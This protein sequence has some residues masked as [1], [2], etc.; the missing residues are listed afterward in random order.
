MERRSFERQVYDY[1]RAIGLTTSQ[2]KTEV[3]RARAMCGELQYDTDDSALENEQR[4]DRGD[5]DRGSAV[6]HDAREVTTAEDS[7]RAVPAPGIRASFSETPKRKSTKHLSSHFSHALGTEVSAKKCKRAGS[8]VPRQDFQAHSPGLPIGV[9]MSSTAVPAKQE[10]E[11]QLKNKKTARR[12]S[13]AP[14]RSSL[15]HQVTDKSEACLG[16]E[17]QADTSRGLGDLEGRKSTFPQT[18]VI[19]RISSGQTSPDDGPQGRKE[20]RMGSQ[21]QKSSPRKTKKQTKRRASF[22]LS[23]DPIVIDSDISDRE[24]SLT[25]YDKFIKRQAAVRQRSKAQT[26]SDRDVDMFASSPRQPQVK[27][28]RRSDDSDDETG[29]ADSSKGDNVSAGDDHKTPSTAG[30]P[31]KAI[32]KGT[33]RASIDS[34]KHVT[35]S[36]SRS[37]EPETS[38]GRSRA[39]S[40]APATRLSTQS[41]LPDSGR[42]STT[43]LS[44]SKQ[45]KQR[46][47]SNTRKHFLK[48]VAR[49]SLP[50]ETQSHIGLSVDKASHVP[51][52][53]S[54]T[55]S[56]NKKR[57]SADRVG[58]LESGTYGETAMSRTPRKR[59]RREKAFRE[60][61]PQSPINVDELEHR[62]SLESPSDLVVIE[63]KQQASSPK[64]S[65][66]INL[67]DGN[68]SNKEVDTAPEGKAVV[69]VPDTKLQDPKSPKASKKDKKTKKDKKD[70]EHRDHKDH[71][72]SKEQNDRKVT[73]EHKKDQKDK[74]GKKRKSSLGHSQES[75][76]KAVTDSQETADV[77][78]QMTT[79][80]Q[81]DFHKPMIQLE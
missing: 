72:K 60:G 56:P 75:P 46:R 59:A 26:S 76:K 65:Q 5:V 48:D 41:P 47:Q 40:V 10:K 2:A 4:L 63:N 12:A 32:E 81:P 53:S 80:S 13:V 55:P 31:K 18:K 58:E 44:Q 50:L 28:E 16:K 62:R 70:R 27:M 36:K 17:K 68:D 52:R 39:T 45:P 3:T 33:S 77:D 78:C 42:K 6:D 57:K 74:K 29:H 43:P 24:T 1:A 38:P 30:L 49:M 71:N 23:S 64:S 9:N 73:K 67:V 15:V 8:E 66:A 14:E 34:D 22:G 54:T 7:S 61:E 35:T 69:L 37:R 25:A 20:G 79:Q 21:S 11:E 19:H 51:Q